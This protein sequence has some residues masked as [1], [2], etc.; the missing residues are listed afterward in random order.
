[1]DENLGSVKN[2]EIVSMLSR[3]SVELLK[4]GGFNLKKF[5]SNI[6]NLSLKLNPLRPALSAVRKF[7]PLRLDRKSHRMFSVSNGTMSPMRWL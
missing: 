7:L 2:P 6:A 5:I 3:S 1:M 4:L